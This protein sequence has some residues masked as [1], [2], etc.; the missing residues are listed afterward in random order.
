LAKEKHV[1]Q[2]KAFDNMIAQ[3]AS[4]GQVREGDGKRGKGGER[5]RERERERLY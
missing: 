1:E 3:H 2:V 5:E 4:A